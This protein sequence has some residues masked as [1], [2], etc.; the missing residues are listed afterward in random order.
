MKQIFLTC[1]KCLD[2]WLF[3]HAH[4]KPNP[5]KCS[6][7][8]LLYIIPNMAPLWFPSIILLRITIGLNTYAIQNRM[9]PKLSKEM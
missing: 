6:Q 7:L 8:S 5:H 3:S 4:P 1:P 9:C 2:V